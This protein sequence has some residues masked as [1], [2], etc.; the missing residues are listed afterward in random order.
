MPEI[1]QI[2]PKQP[3]AIVPANPAD[4]QIIEHGRDI[5]MYKV[6][7]PEI[8]ELMAS[9]M[10]IDFGLFTLCVGTFVALSLALITVPQLPDRIF[11]VF[12]ALV[13]ASLL[14]MI[15]FGFRTWIERRRV[16]QRIK[17]IKESQSRK[18]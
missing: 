13:F 9:Y 4:V 10:S 16:N 1:K 18:I 3:S 7:E 5:H 17:Q 15:F 14:G 12:I 6:T 11:S 8:N 2:A